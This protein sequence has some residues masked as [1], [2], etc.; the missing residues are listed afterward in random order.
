MTLYALSIQSDEILSKIEILFS[1]GILFLLFAILSILFLTT[2]SKRNFSIPLLIFSA[3]AV[4]GVIWLIFDE[5]IRP[6]LHFEQDASIR[7]DALDGSNTEVQVTWIYWASRPA[8]FS[9]DPSRWEPVKDFSFSSLEVSTSFRFSAI[10]LIALDALL[11]CLAVS[12][13]NDVS[14][15]ISRESILSSLMS[16]AFHKRKRLTNSTA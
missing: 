2:P 4:G 14:I 6:S 12:L 13:P 7:I 9:S 15:C 5:Q 16:A 1:F 11:I 8:D 3:L 10:R